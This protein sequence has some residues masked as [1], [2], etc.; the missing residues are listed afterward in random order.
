M[1]RKPSNKNETVINGNS[2]AFRNKQILLRGIVL[3]MFNYDREYR[4]MTE[5]QLGAMIIKEHY[6]RNPPS[7]FVPKD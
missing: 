6:R 7:G 1:G 4:D 3:E 2:Y 5:S